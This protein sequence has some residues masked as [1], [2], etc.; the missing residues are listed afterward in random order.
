MGYAMIHYKSAHPLTT[1]DNMAEIQR[2]YFDDKAHGRGF[3][4]ILMERVLEEIGNKFPLIWL[5]VWEENPRA[6]RFYSKYGFEQ[7]GL[8][9]FHVGSVIDRDWIMTRKV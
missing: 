9:E 7:L 3:A 5:G 1:D 2:F 6:I 4:H 8:K